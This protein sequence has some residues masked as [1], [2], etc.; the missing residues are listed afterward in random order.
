VPS[1]RRCQIPF[2]GTSIADEEVC[3]YG[4]SA[5]CHGL[6]VLRSIGDGKVDFDGFRREIVVP[7][8]EY[9]IRRFGHNSAVDNRS[10]HSG[11][12][13]EDSVYIRAT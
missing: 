9:C 7:L 5:R 8:D 1:K 13:Y 12:T 10:H 4:T 3:R 6:A 11:T 2:I